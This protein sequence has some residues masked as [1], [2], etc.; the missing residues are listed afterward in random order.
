MKNS[1]FLVFILLAIYFHSA[2][3]IDSKKL[4]AID[5]PIKSQWWTEYSSNNCEQE[6][7]DNSDEAQVC[8]SEIKSCCNRGYCV[9]HTEAGLI[10]YQEVCHQNFE[11][12][13]CPWR[14]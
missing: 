13:N 3:T 6:C 12:T 5:K 14:T 11:L 10:K 1:P 7:L 9:E 2:F 8:G 4:I